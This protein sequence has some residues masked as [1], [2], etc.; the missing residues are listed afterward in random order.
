MI[1]SRNLTQ[2]TGRLTADP[3]YNET[4]GV[5]NFSVAQDNAGRENGETVSGFFDVTVWVNP[6]DYTP[7]ALGNYVKNAIADK[8]LAKGSVVEITG[9]LSQERWE[10]DGKKNSK[11]V[12]IAENVMVTWSHAG[13]EKRE[14]AKAESGP[15]SNSAA[16][17]F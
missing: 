14:A 1:N 4:V 16:D 9:R 7:V 11:I 13:A 10:R 17:S 6:S 5:V 12:I 8:T 15:V 2:I 3:N